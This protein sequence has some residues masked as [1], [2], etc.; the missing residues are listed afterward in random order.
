MSSLGLLLIVAILGVAAMIISDDI[1][2]NDDITN[3]Y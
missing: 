3:Y 1:D 2:N